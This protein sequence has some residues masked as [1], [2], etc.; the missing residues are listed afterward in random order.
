MRFVM[1][2]KADPMSEAGL[3]P[4]GEELEAVHRFNE[5]MVR[6]G[7]LLAAEGFHPTARGA[8][9]VFAQRRPTVVEGP[10]GQP[11]DQVAGFWMIQVRS[12]EEAIEWATRVPFVDGQVELRQ[13]FESSELV[14]GELRA[15]EQLLRDTVRVRN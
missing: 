12:R 7:V 11:D 5:E 4:T 10:F 2:V 15:R 8:R 3:L 9:I 1:L 13:V 14:A 6:S